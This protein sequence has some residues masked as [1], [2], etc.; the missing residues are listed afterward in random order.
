MSDLKELYEAL[1]DG[2]KR[3][4]RND[5]KL[6]FGCKSTFH[7]KIRGKVKLK[8]AEIVFFAKNLNQK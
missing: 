1:S 8:N 2:K 7:N 3:K 4:L 5:Y 6:L